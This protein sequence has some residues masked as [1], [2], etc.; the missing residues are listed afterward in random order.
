MTDEPLALLNVIKLIS[1]DVTC[2]TLYCM[3]CLEYGLSSD[4]I[5]LLFLLLNDTI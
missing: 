2:K 3:I 5:T 4:H 1:L